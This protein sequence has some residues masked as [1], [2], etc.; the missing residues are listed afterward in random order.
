MAA[1]GR[2]RRANFPAGNLLEKRQTP[3]PSSGKGGLAVGRGDVRQG[4]SRPVGGNAL[5]SVRRSA[6]PST[7][8]QA[9]AGDPGPQRVG[10]P[11]NKFPSKPSVPV[12]RKPRKPQTRPNWLAGYAL[13]H[14]TPRWPVQDIGTL[15]QKSLKSA[16]DW[17]ENGR[18]YVS[19]SLPVAVE[20]I[21]ALPLSPPGES[22]VFFYTHCS[23]SRI[24]VKALDP[25]TNAVTKAAIEGPVNR[26]MTT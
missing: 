7:A 24:F 25:A 18:Y 19:S 9:G 15:A 6:V 5:A 21:K 3:L 23:P 12:P 11:R 10:E 22:A 16:I 14:H 20:P 26:M 13:C 2:P 1:G 17:A 4:R 8:F